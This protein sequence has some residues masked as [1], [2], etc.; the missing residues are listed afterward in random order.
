MD[1]LNW[2]SANGVRI[3]PNIRILHD[4][5][6]G[7]C[8]NAARCPIIPE[9]SRKHLAPISQPSAIF[10]AVLFSDNPSLF[11]RGCQLS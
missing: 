9:Q 1:L 10:A 3:H 4:E 6:R 11:L 2:S 7:I 8:V 5:N